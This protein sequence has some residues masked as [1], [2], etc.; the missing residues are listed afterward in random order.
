MTDKMTEAELHAVLDNVKEGDVVRVMIEGTSMKT[1]PHTSDKRVFSLNNGALFVRDH[2]RQFEFASN[3]ISVEN[4]G[5]PEPP[6]PEVGSFALLD[7]GDICTRNPLRRERTLGQ[8]MWFCISN[9]GWTTWDDIKSQVKV[10]YHP[11]GSINE[12]WKR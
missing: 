6:E 11:D 10:L 8:E 4:L 5:Q 9:K 1:T 7:D 3:L 12:G 2:N